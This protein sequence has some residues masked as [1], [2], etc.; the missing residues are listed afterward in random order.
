MR[1]DP[2]AA[3]DGFVI[4]QGWIHQRQISQQA[5][6]QIEAVEQPP[7][8]EIEQ[9]SAA[10]AAGVGRGQAPR[11]KQVAHSEHHATAQP[12]C[13]IPQ[14]QVGHADIDLQIGAMTEAI[15]EMEPVDAGPE[16]GHPNH[17]DICPRRPKRLVERVIDH[18]IA[19]I[20]HQ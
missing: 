6:G 18:Q 3:G 1:G 17:G 20:L 2:P 10:G 8:D 13:G 14:R 12:V 9:R 5:D 4:G 19:V 7:D 16:A 11:L 15:G